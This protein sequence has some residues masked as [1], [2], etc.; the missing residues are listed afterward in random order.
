MPG[1]LVAELYGATVSISASWFAESFGA[2][3]SISA[4]WSSFTGLT[5]LVL[6][7]RVTIV[8]ILAFLRGC[9]A[10]K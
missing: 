8:D 5:G 4:S 9:F 3:V 2:T 6:A 1:L 7:L 10:T